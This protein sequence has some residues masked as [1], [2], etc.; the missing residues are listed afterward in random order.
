MVQRDFDGPR[1]DLELGEETLG[2]WVGECGLVWL[3]GN[4]APG[5]PKTLGVAPW[6]ILASEDR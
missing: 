5:S 2:M 4:A 6:S 3:H 1:Y